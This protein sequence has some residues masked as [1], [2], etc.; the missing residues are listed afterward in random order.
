MTRDQYLAQLA[1]ASLALIIIESKQ[2]HFP[3]IPED[4]PG[5]AFLETLL[6]IKQGS[7][8]DHCTQENHTILTIDAHLPTEKV[9]EVRIKSED[10]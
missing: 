4:Q 9:L 7:P 2:C 6:I 1:Q 3:D 10:G 8:P 5:Q